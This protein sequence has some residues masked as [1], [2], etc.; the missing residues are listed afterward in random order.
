MAVLNKIRERSV[1]LI[2][3]IALALFSFVLADVIRN[4]GFSSQ[5]SQNVIAT[6]NDEPI[7]REEFAR[8][9]E[10]YQRNSRGNITTTQ[11]VNQVWNSMLN[12]ALL[13]EEFEKLGIEVGQEQINNVLRQQF[14]GNPNFTNE[15][16][17]FDINLMREYIANLK[18]TSPEA[19][20]QWIDVEENIAEQA[21]ANIYYNMVRA[22]IGATNLE[23]KQA[24]KLEND[25]VDFKFVYLP[26]DTVEDEEIS[27]SE[28]K[29]YINRHKKQYETEAT[30]NI[31]YVFF[32]ESASKEDEQAVEENVTSLLQQREVYNEVSKMN[33]TLKGFKDVENNEAFLVENSDLPYQERF[34]FK[35][36]LPAE[37][38][39]NISNLNQGETFGPYKEGGFYKVSKVTAVKQIP[40]SV[41][42]KDILISYQGTPVG[43]ELTRTKEEA[44]QL[45]DSL[46]E[47]LNNDT[48][49]FGEIAA[50]YSS[51]TSTKDNGGDLGWIT[52]SQVNQDSD[53]IDFL[54]TQDEGKVG[55]VEDEEIGFYILL[56]E[57]QT[58]AKK[59]FKVATLGKEIEPSETTQNRLF[60]EVT[61]FEIASGE[62]DFV[63]Q[64]EEK[65]Y[66]TKP[67]KSIKNMQENIPGIG[68]QRQIV[69]WTF[70]EETKAGD[71]K[72]FDTPNGYVVVQ[73]TA[74]NKK[75]L[76]SVEEASPKVTPVLRREKKAE[77]IKAEIN[78]SSLAEIASS[79]N[80]SVQTA[81][82]VTRKNPTIPGASREPKVVGAA[83]ALETGETSK[84]IAGRKGVYVVEVTNKT[85]APELG[86]YATFAKQETQ[87][88]NARVTQ[89]LTESLKNSAEIE[90]NRAN[91]Y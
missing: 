50:N 46:V 17:M 5:K 23:G 6:V 22:G 25:K 32:E 29:D 64:A 31:Q 91:F 72:R 36:D 27:K 76:M 63:K 40:D 13:K 65:G 18:A 73:V 11:A 55:I 52:Y 82:A 24:Y 90:D 28:I 66:E 83:F 69:Q 68:N 77:K 57:E 9:V 21:K 80:A 49:K 16:G 12:Q 38:A 88:S 84:P 54:F 39:N 45:A 3:I 7:D 2:I 81:N 74:V 41:K 78:S 59:A 30:R 42:A 47:V 56:P 33:D 89:R 75:G 4:G 8:Q 60:T 79:Q 19:Y 34:M 35:T 26:Y 67:V 37:N 51:D 85:E 44:K 61:K 58:E 71:I 48:S 20:S 43:Q 15:A 14:A 10:S 62:G 70:S 87:A 86:S 53:V 1:F